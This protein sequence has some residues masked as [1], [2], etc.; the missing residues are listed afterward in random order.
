MR[1]YGGFTLVELLVMIAVI[2]VLA[3]ILIFGRGFIAAG[4][5]TKA[6]EGMDIIRK[7]A[8]TYAGQVGGALTTST[9]SELPTLSNRQLLPTLDSATSTW[10]VSG[11]GTDSIS[12][13]NLRFGQLAGANVVAI[14]VSTPKQE[15]ADD[16][17]KAVRDDGFLIRTGGPTIGGSTCA[18]GSPATSVVVI[19]FNL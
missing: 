6:V 12:I 3:G 1:R 4:R 16:V 9:N 5:I 11:A 13:T 7:S 18:A 10:F 2:A 19:C 17:W 15:M 8:S 14:T